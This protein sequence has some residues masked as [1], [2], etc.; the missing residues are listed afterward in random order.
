MRCPRCGLEQ[1]F[2]T[3]GCV[4]CGYTLRRNS[5]GLSSHLNTMTSPLTGSVGVATLRQNAT[6]NK[7]RYRL[8]SEARVPE[9]QQR[10]GSA[11][12]ASDTKSLNQRVIIREIL[13]PG[14]LARGSSAEKV[15]Y[16]VAQRLRTLGGQ[17]GLPGVS[18]FFSEQGAYFIVCSYPGG[19]A[20]ASLLKRYGGALPEEQ[21]AAY[22]YQICSQL[23]VLASQQPPLIH[24]S[25]N[26]ETIFVD[27]EQHVASL[28]FLP[29]FTP[30][31]PPSSA[32]RVSAG[33]YAPEQVHN[34]LSPA[35]DLYGLAVT[36]H[37]MLT[38]YDPHSRL[39]LF[40]P[41]ARRLNPTVTT[42][43]ELLLTRQLSLSTS[44]RYPGP[45]EMQKDLQALL[46]AYPDPSLNESAQPVVNPLQM[47][48]TEL[49][50]RSRNMLMLNMG[51]F[52]AICVLMLIGIL[53]VV[54]R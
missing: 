28:A 13:V 47:S 2:G 36:M 12:V 26:P 49:H 31:A 35:T 37:H 14:E 1:D 3:G 9:T 16:T 17:A 54:L 53:L 50:E 34:E 32:G 25:I 45:A 41:P 42:Q 4:R 18:D 8:M 38:G 6:L 10:Q 40:H 19:V 29:L 23:S 52:A 15:C 5:G 24:G 11:W 48:S 46:E 22:S 27:E 30:D 7:G 44:Q 43:M 21:V 39:A 33:Y 51:V 20:L